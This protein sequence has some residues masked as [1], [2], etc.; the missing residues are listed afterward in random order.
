MAPSP[1]VPREGDN[2]ASERMGTEGTYTVHK[3]SKNTVTIPRKR[4]PGRADFGPST[5][6]KFSLHALHY[7]NLS[8]H[9]LNWQSVVEQPHP[10]AFE[11]GDVGRDRRSGFFRGKRESPWLADRNQIGYF[12]P[13]TATTARFNACPTAAAWNEFAHHPWAPASRYFLLTGR[14]Y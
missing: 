3:G 10:G 13:L 6:E 7:D 11:P 1:E 9:Q 12:T 4:F 2:R 14:S 8:L 5:P